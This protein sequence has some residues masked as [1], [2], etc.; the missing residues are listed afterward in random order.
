M[1]PGQN[2]AFFVFNTL[3][4]PRT[5]IVDL[6]Y[7]G[8]DSIHVI[9]V[10]TGDQV[11]WQV[12]TVDGE[13]Y[14]RILADNVPPVGYKMY[15]IAPGAGK[16]F[17]PAAVINGPSMESGLY[18]VTLNEQGAISSLIHQMYGEFAQEIDGSLIN[19]LGAGDMTVSR[20]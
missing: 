10:S 18:T 20:K 17:P 5:D 15:E 12:E 6:P 8:S 2:P 14:L 11:P 7:D 19:D 9:D 3:N 1:A 16:A 4:W 13:R